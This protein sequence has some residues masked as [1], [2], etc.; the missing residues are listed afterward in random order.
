MASVSNISHEDHSD[1]Q[2]RRSKPNS[3]LEHYSSNMGP[4]QTTVF[5]P[6]LNM[7]ILTNG[8]TIFL[9]SC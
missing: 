2:N 3:G 6:R 7:T 1:F 8:C 4:L 9:V 5:M